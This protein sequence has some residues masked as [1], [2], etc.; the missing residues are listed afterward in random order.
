VEEEK[1]QE[2]G[3]A[4]IGNA[5][6]AIPFVQTIPSLTIRRALARL[7]RKRVKKF[8]ALAPEIRADANPKTVHDVRVWSRR[9]Q[10]A[11]G[12]FFPKPRSGKVRRLRRTPRRIRRAL[13]EWRNCDVLLEIVERRQRRTRSDA[14]RQAWG[15]VRD[16]LLQKRAK[17]VTRA[18]KKLRRQELGDYAALAQKLLVRPAEESPELLMQRLCDSVEGAWTEWQ[19]ALTRA[20]ETGALGDLHAFRIATKNLRYRTELLRDV[21]HKHLKA[22]LKWLAD[23]QDAIGVWHDRQVLY[24]AVA[25]AVARTETLLHERPTVRILLAE[26]EKDCKRE[27]AEVEKIFRL[28]IEHPKRLPPAPNPSPPT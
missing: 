20:Q 16:Y 4:G 14:K 28:A 13:G 25:K 27:R 15:F 8:V 18:G 7:L 1:E 22:Q 6:P 5:D 19:S 9:L 24:Q 17:E 23:L 26:L 2:L 12:A 21:G 3:S 11:L 10:Q